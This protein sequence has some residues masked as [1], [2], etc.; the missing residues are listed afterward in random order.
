M[1]CNYCVG[2]MKATRYGESK[3][4]CQSCEFITEILEASISNIN[5]FPKYSKRSK[6]YWSELISKLINK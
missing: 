2:E 4:V 3:D 6:E 5:N 1:K